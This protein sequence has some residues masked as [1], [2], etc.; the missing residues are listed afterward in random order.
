MALSLAAQSSSFAAEPPVLRASLETEPTTLDWSE[1][2]SATDRYLISYLMRGLLKYDA[3]NQP[4]CDLCVSFSVS[5]DQKVYRFELKPGE[6]WSDGQKLTAQQFV[7]S[8]QRLLNPFHRFR[9]A[10]EFGMIQGAH[11]EGAGAWDAKKLAVVSEGPSQLRIELSEPSAIFPHLLTTVAAYPIRKELVKKDGGESMASAA[12]LGPYQLAA[13][14]R[15]KRLVIEGN[16]KY[17]AERPV[18]RVDFV[19]GA[20]ADQ[21]RKFKAGKVDILANPTTEDLL[22]LKGQKIQVSP[23]WSTRGILFNASRKLP[24]EASL[25]RAILYSLDRPSL[26]SFLKNGERVVGG[27]IPP[28]LSGAR[29]LPLATADAARART[30]LAQ[31]RSGKSRGLKLRLLLRDQ[32]TDRQVARWL[33]AQLS[34]IGIQ[35]EPEPRKFAAYE[36]ALEKGDFDLTLTHWVF[37]VATPLD[38]LKDFRT[39]A[40]RNYARWTDVGYDSLLAQLLHSPVTGAHKPQALHQLT[41]TLEAQEAVAIPLGYPT[42]PFLL[43]KRVLGFAVTPFGEPDLV[44]IQLHR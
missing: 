42:Q 27:L 37:D 40:P 22:Q 4:V 28:G 31:L 6:L 43:G 10:Q 14:E 18:Y 16:P 11:Q 12:V 29:A 8:F 23:T 9:G 26:P 21:L 30:E 3:E 20:H 15:G 32:P 35:L 36:S 25:R 2:R 17:A 13:W 7:D 44:K 24:G 19:L 39:G 38:L 1:A 33:E 34:K 41:Q 5:E